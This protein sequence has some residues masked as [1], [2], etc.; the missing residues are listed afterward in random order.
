M[1]VAFLNA[2]C[3]GSTGKIISEIAEEGLNY[4]IES[5]LLYGRGETPAINRKNAI[6]VNS[7][8]NFYQDA[9]FS[10]LLD[11]QGL[12]SFI[13]TK[14]SLNILDTF[15]PD[16]IHL[17]NLHGY[18]MNYPMLFKYIKANNIPVV[19]TLHDCWPVTGHCAYYEYLNCNNRKLGCNNC[20]GMN[21]Y[22]KS[23]VDRATIA[24]AKKKEYFNTVD[25]MFIVTPSEWLANIVHNSFLSKFPIGVIRNGVSDRIFRP[26]EFGYLYKKYKIRKDCK[27]VLYV[28]MN[29]NDPWKGFS[30]VKELYRLLSEKYQ[31]I[32]VGNCD[33]QSKDRLIN[34]GR[35]ENQQ[36]LAAFYSMADILVN[37]SLDDNYP[38][39]NLESLACGTPIVAFNT[40]GIPE[41]V[42]YNVGYICTEKTAE[43]LRQGIERICS[44][45]KTYFKNKCIEKY[46]K[47]NGQQFTTKYI[48]LY[49]NL[50]N[51]LEE[52]HD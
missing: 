24:F 5:L 52:K 9:L 22:P 33:L 30:F 25:R 18:W 29:T 21:Y 35:T 15:K 4:G 2:W 47:L 51:T 23:Y 16:I 38:T 45:E 49:Q 8:F 12:N 10:R 26:T 48:N 32:I 6:N 31:I 14:K 34:I 17:H 40:G 41:Q 39:V 43:S 20:P 37:P 13:A 28:A 46:K 1:R 44:L 42:D 11:N 36:E 3:N 7:V 27:I 19:W 50:L